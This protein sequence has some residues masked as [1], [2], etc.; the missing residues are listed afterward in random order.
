MSQRDLSDE[1]GVSADVIVKLEHDARRP[2]PSTV[3]RLAETLGVSPEYLTTG[4]D[5]VARAAPESDAWG[6]PIGVAPSTIE[7]GSLLPRPKV[8]ISVTGSPDEG[9][10]KQLERMF[11][12]WM[13]E[14][15]ASGRPDAWPEIAR[16]MDE[17][18]TSYRKLF[19]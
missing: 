17:D 14:D 13:K 2:R 5:S 10:A 16:A 1:S 11:E 12:R 7:R 3:K 4:R 6:T 8:E 9:A 18:R 15:E 19:R